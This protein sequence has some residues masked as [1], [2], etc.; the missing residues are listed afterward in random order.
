L[1]VFFASLFAVDSLLRSIAFPPLVPSPRKIRSVG[2]VA[3]MSKSTPTPPTQHD[4]RFGPWRSSAWGPNVA[5][6]AWAPHLRRAVASNAVIEEAGD[7]PSADLARLNRRR[8][9]LHDGTSVEIASPEK[10]A[11]RELL[12]VL[13]QAIAQLGRPATSVKRRAA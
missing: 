1:G 2:V 6:A 9:E 10:L 13:Q 7:E 5:P 4:G 12:A 8:I 11:N 3:E